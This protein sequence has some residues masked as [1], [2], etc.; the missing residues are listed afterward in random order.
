MMT[1]FKHTRIEVKG[2]TAILIIDSAPVNAL[3]EE[4]KKE[5]GKR[6]EDLDSQD[7]I[8]TI[9]LTA[10]GDKIFAAGAN[11][12]SLLNLGPGEGLKRVQE[13]KD[14]YSRVANFEKPIIAA[15]NGTCLGGGLE[16]VLCCDFRIAA[17]H[18]K[19]GFPE[20]NL[21]IM[22]GAGGTQR[23][24]RLINP[25]LA[26]YLIYTG[27]IITAGEAL[28]Y[29]LVTKV[30]PYGSLMEEAE[31]MARRL[32]EK[33]PLAVRAAKRAISQGY[34]LPLE[35]GLALENEI[36]ATLCDTQDKREG[37]SSFLEKRK[38]EFKGI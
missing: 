35:K 18:V 25:S 4:L 19:L 11:I 10:A 7:E 13:V 20:V 3:G 21:G 32:N 28:S 17:D 36:W 29:G 12:P 1:A 6:F 31:E 37:I 15:L 16:L 24:P 2:R 14:L 26:R 5:I 30:V 22:P 33:G 9:I 27:S 23:L 38:P 34:D 8:W